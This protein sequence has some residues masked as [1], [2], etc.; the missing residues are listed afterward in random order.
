MAVNS[1][2]TQIKDML[3]ANWALAS[4]AAADIA[5]TVEWYDARAVD[6][7]Y[8]VTVTHWYSPPSRWFGPNY[9]DMMLK[10]F[11]TD[12]YQVNVWVRIPRGDLTRNQELIAWNMKNEVWRLLNANR[13]QFTPPIGLV[14]PLDYGRQLNEENA[15]RTPRILRWMIEVQANFKN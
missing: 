6:T 14:I 8:Q 15:D 11:N 4:P 9:P 2:A 7:E 1:V 5:F 10:A 3:E 12:R 13:D